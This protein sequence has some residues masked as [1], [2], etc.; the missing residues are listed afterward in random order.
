MSIG[1]RNPRR[2]LSL[3]AALC[4]IPVVGQTVGVIRSLR[5]SSSQEAA[6][7][8]ARVL[9]NP[10]DTDARAELLQLYLN[11]APPPP[12]DDPARRSL[13][14]QHILYLVEHHPESAASVS[15]AAFVHSVRGPYANPSDHDVVRGQWAA[16]VQGHPKDTAVI[17]NA[18][19][20]LEVEDKNDAERVLLRA[21]S[22]NPEDRE[23]AANLGFL[24]AHEILGGDRSDQAKAELE[25]SSNAVV[26]AA[27]GTA[28]PNLAVKSSAGR[29]VDPKLF[30]L[31][32]QLSAR[33]RQLA[34]DDA[35]IQGPMPLIKYFA[36]MQGDGRS[37][38]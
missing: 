33:A 34:P 29:S 18:V 23:I 22:A 30:E 17:L 3:L 6:D 19:R 13:R 21:M 35:D 37:I 24:Y 8:E 38:P 1:V 15:K 11:A 5:L 10:G 28:L 14:L 7:L 26:L 12:L 2:L 9:Q 20:F 32:S 4:A 25:R 36:Q 31:A 27:A 16:A